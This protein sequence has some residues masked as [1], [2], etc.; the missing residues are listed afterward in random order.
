MAQNRRSSTGPFHVPKPTTNSD[1]ND[2]DFGRSQVKPNARTRHVRWSDKMDG[3]MI[4]SLVEQVLAGH[5]RSDNGFT[6][7]QV[8]KAID[9]VLNGCGVMVSDKNVR[10]RLKTLKKEHA[11]V[12]QLLN[13]SGFGLDPET[14]RIVADV[15]AWDE[16]IKGKPKFGKWRTKL[17]PRYDE[18][19][20][21]FGNDAAT[22][23][24][25][26][27]GFDHFSLMNVTDES[28]NEDELEMT[29]RVLDQKGNYSG[30]NF[31]TRNKA[32]GEV[33]L[34]FPKP[35]SKL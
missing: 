18:M 29:S 7:F 35:A 30:T 14:G 34:L 1:G 5:K 6:S 13:M 31:L 11:E 21:I 20:T 32:T 4:T 33:D 19:E 8:S 25:A 15:V 27:S 2:I 17:C 12:R 28:V 24:R 9:R 23:E 10:A 3:F 16:F 26:V 22:G